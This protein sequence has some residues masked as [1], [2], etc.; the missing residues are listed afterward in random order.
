MGEDMSNEVVERW[1]E[2]SS[3]LRDEYVTCLQRKAAVI[4]ELKEMSLT[5]NDGSGA[6]K[7]HPEK[8]Q[9]IIE[10]VEELFKEVQNKKS[11]LMN[12]LLSWQYKTSFNK[13][14]LVEKQMLNII[15]DGQLAVIRDIC[16]QFTEVVVGK[17]ER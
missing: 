15:I 9:S 1:K 17:S 2:I 8:R 6:S 16:G 14:I 13:D 11:C 3:Y 7:Q 12:D 10:I 4:S 5:T